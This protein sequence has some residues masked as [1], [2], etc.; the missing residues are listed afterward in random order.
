MNASVGSNQ[1]SSAKSG[2]MSISARDS[3]AAPPELEYFHS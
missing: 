3:S 1:F 2:L